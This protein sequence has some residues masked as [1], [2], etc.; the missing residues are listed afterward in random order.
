MRDKSS[1][2]PPADFLRSL[3]PS[4]SSLDFITGLPPFNGNTTILITVD[5]QSCSFCSPHPVPLSH[6]DGLAPRAPCVSSTRNS[7]RHGVIS[8]P[9]FTSGVWEAFCRALGAM[10]SLSSGYHPLTNGQPEQA[11]QHLESMLRFAATTNPS[12]WSTHLP[13]TKYT[14]NLQTSAATSPST[15]EVSLGYQPPMFPSQEENIAVPFAQHHLR[16]CRRVWSL[17]RRALLRAGGVCLGST[18]GGG[19]VMVCLPARLLLFSLPSGAPGADCCHLL[20]LLI[21]GPFPHHCTSIYSLSL[22][23]AVARSSVFHSRR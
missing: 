21:C 4:V 19:S 7:L 12:S 20:T 6:Q 9:Q 1:H 15:A 5:H 17:T 10:V 8:G 11:N 14:Y 22:L 13:L 3:P 23:S 18:V 16:H 2:R